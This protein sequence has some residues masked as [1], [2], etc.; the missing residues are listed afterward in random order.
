VRRSILAASVLGAAIGAVLALR[1]QPVSVEVAS[2]TLGPL[3][4][5]VEE[6]GM[7]RV[8]D[9]YLVSAPVG[10]HVSRLALDPGD[11]VREGDILAEIA[12]AA[13]PLLDER[14]RAAAEARLG[15]ALSAFGQAK[16][17]AERA[18]AAKDFADRE[19]AR[20]EQLAKAGTLAPQALE[21]AQF[22]ATTR[23]AEVAS[24]IFAT[25]VAQ[26]EVRI[27]RV[28]LGRNAG[29]GP[30]DHHVDVLSPIG[31]RVLRV[32][33]KSAAVLP[34]GAALVEVGDPSA[35][36]IIVDLLT[37]DA[38]RVSPGTPVKIDGWGGDRALSGRVRK[39]EPSAF[40]RPS[41][42]GVDEQ[43]VNVL[44]V[45]TD[46]PEAWAALC[47][48]YR[49][50]AHLVLWRG[51]NVLRV[52]HGSVFRQGAGWAVFRVDDGIARLTPVTLGH[53]GETEVEVLSGLTPS[54]RIAVHPG[55]RV[56]DGVRVEGR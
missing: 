10:G 32:H 56:K 20:T 37:T 18:A 8:K 9:R 28:S 12:P 24:T 4:V 14:T 45:P 29:R 36:E 6:S 15:A 13:S 42:L 41:A 21:Q 33:Q 49:V 7:T 31:G 38:V 51:E 50:Q 52:P 34:A 39:I 11:V 27:A 40:T 17:Q 23:T 2:A 19:L 26:E 47:D 16:A 48:G 55:D 46:P 3:M 54:S 44:I 30:S 22:A 25:K 53:R 35:L 5:E 43:R 1:P